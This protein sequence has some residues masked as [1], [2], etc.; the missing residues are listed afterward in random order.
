MRSGRPGCEN[1]NSEPQLLYRAAQLL[2]SGYVAYGIGNQI[3]W[4]D[5]HRNHSPRSKKQILCS[6]VP[7]ILV[8]TG[9][10]KISFETP[11]LPRH[12][13]SDVAVKRHRA[14]LPH[15]AAKLAATYCI[16]IIG[17]CNGCHVS[18]RE[19]AS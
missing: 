11:R 13:H 16:E 6:E 19:K 5:D 18:L 4:G 3:D 17:C 8:N 14:G 12:Q 7:E 10:A 1:L 2:Q 15:A 9:L